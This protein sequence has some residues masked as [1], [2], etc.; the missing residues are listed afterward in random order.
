MIDQAHRIIDVIK[1]RQEKKTCP[2][3]LL[4]EASLSTKSGNMAY[5]ITQYQPIHNCIYWCNEI[6][7]EG[8]FFWLQ[9]KTIILNEKNKR[10]KCLSRPFLGTYS[11][12]SLHLGQ[13]TYR[14]CSN[15]HWQQRSSQAAQHSTNSVHFN[16][17]LK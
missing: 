2:I 11:L 5:S 3:L 9:H 13:S 14:K 6:L 12:F 10:Q 15:W 8:S 7:Y 16:R 4:S 17:K 1:I